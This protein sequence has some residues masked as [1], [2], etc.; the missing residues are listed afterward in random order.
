[1]PVGSLLGTIAGA[2]VG[3]ATGDPQMGMSIGSG[4]GQMVDASIANRKSNQAFPD[5]VS[6]NQASFLAELNMKRKAL[7]TGADNAMINQQAD[8]SQ[9]SANNAIVNSAGGNPTQAIS[10]ILAAQKN[11]GMVKNAG[12]AQAMNTQAMYNSAYQNMLN[13]IEEKKFQAQMYQSQQKKAEWAALTR[14]ANANLMAGIGRATTPQASAQGAQSAIPGLA[15]PPIVPMSNASASE[16]DH[17]SPIDTSNSFLN[18]IISKS[19]EMN[20]GAGTGVGI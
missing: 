8:L 7:E 1:M 6:P 10:A 4:L 11:A 13:L 12:A 3:A 20:I 16:I 17:V 9:A 18:D 2:G 15:T 5:Y 14:D 19:N